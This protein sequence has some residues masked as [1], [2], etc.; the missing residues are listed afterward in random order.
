MG[1]V[2]DS[3]YKLV[4]PE[5]SDDDGNALEIRVKPLS[6]GKWLAV[7]NNDLEHEELLDLFTE[8][9]AWWNLE[10]RDQDGKVAPVPANREGVR[11]QDVMFILQLINMWADRIGNVSDPLPE[12]SSGGR[13][14]LEASLPMEP[15]SESLA[16]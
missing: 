14:S 5:F 3:T 2:R 12:T 15:L 16:S 10:Q 11:S 13:P 1:Y 8:H 4:F 6:V 9:L 7:V